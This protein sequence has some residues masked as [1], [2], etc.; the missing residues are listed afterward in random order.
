MGAAR[1]LSWKKIFF[2]FLASFVIILL[3]TLIDWLVH[4]AHWS[5][6]VPPGYFSNKIIFGTIYFFISILIFEKLNYL[7]KTLVATTI[8]VFL[9]QIRYIV[10]GYSLLF[11][12]VIFPAHFIILF[13]I[14]W[15]L[16]KLKIKTSIKYKFKD[17]RKDFQNH[18]EKHHSS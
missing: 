1:L 16:L 15:G 14:S 12:S 10:T 8:T 4:Q 9:L 6:S 5:L 7:H 11:H 13:L 2:E 18:I 3:F 17:L